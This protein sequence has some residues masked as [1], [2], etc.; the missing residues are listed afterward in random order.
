M[1]KTRE[2]QK[3]QLT[4]L[5]VQGLF[6]QGDVIWTRILKEWIHITKVDKTKT[7]FSRRYSSYGQKMVDIC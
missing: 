2:K 1:P 7:L 6:H 5:D 4:F 3:D